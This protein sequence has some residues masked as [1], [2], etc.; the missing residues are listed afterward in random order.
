MKFQK[1]VAA[2]ND[3]IVFKE[4][5]ISNIDYCSLAEK[6]CHRKFGLGADGI[7]IACESSFADIKMLYYNSDGTEGEMCGNGLRVFA[8]F[9]YDNN[10]LRKE[11]LTV[12]TLDGVK[13]VVLK[14]S[15]GNLKLMEVNMGKPIFEASNI[16]IDLNENEIVNKKIIIDGREFTFSAL[17]VGVPHVVIFLTSE[18]LRQIANIEEVGRKIESHKL[19]PERT[20]VNFVEKVDDNYIRIYTWE[21]GSGRTLACG[22]GSCSAVV[23]GNRLGLL[24]DRVDVKTEGGIIQ[25]SLENDEVIMIGRASLIAKGY[26]NFD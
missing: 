21:R 22:T 19:F 23:V 15:D 17:R 16:P 7:I 4:E 3:F 18:D 8:K 24:K 20:N 26:Y 11:I 6:V 1:Y 13:Q 10:I 2:G 5:D 9:I 25:V 12:E 14:I